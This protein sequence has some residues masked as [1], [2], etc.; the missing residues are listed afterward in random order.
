MDDSHALIML[1]LKLPIVLLVM[2]D[3]NEYRLVKDL[4]RGYDKRIRPSLNASEPLNVTFGL[5]LSQL[6]D[7]DEKN[8]ILTTNCWLNQIWIDYSLR[9]DSEEYGGIKVVRLPYG[10]VWRPDILLYNK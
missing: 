3:E 10:S 9:W 1:M 8:Q 6:I 4:M 5:A 2:A 7:V